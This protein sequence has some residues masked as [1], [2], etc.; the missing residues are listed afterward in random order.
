MFNEY[1]VKEDDTLSKIAESNNI[2]VDELINANT[3]EQVELK[4]GQKL[5]I[6]VSENQPFFYYTIEEGDNLSKIADAYGIDR[7]KL[8]KL[9]GLDDNTILFVGN[10]LVIP[11]EGIDFYITK[12]NDTIEQVLSVLNKTYDDISK[13]NKVIYLV[14]NQ[15][16]LYDE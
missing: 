1:I 6:P 14:P 16:I 2:S 5:I 15:L 8:A 4:Q 3:M 7:S 12:E 10:R 13:K 11:K 9:N